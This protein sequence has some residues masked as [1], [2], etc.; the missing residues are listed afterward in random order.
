MKR[1]EMH[2]FSCIVL[3]PINKPL[4]M[5]LI[6]GQLHCAK[7][8]NWKKKRNTQTQ[9]D[10]IQENWIYNN[11]I[12]SKQCTSKASNG[13][14]TLFILNNFSEKTSSP[15]LLLDKQT[16]KKTVQA[17]DDRWKTLKTYYRKTRYEEWKKGKLSNVNMYPTSEDVINQLK[18]LFPHKI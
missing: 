12:D 17:K 14:V 13:F 11:K 2:V 15:L 5:I 10:M 8:E 7:K 18:I 16:D 9:S 3:L 6:S 1:L 4:D